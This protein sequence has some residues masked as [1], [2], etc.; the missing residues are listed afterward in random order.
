MFG[1]FPLGFS[2]R[3]LTIPAAVISG[4]PQFVWADAEMVYRQSN[5]AA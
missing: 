2:S 3:T 5:A 1:M 4:F